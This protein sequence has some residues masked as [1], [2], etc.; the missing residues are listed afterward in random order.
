MKYANLHVAMKMRRIKQYELGTTLGLSAPTVSLKLSG[1]I[2][3]TPE[4]RQK[5]ADVLGYTADW[6]FQELTPPRSATFKR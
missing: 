6:L 1:R 5:I 3:M 2:A 4:E